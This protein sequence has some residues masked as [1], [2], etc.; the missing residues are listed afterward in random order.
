MM[1]GPTCTDFKPG[2]SSQDCRL[3]ARM[4]VLEAGEGDGCTSGAGQAAWIR[5]HP[6]F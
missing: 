1:M 2:L 3:Q 4:F 6:T 5:S